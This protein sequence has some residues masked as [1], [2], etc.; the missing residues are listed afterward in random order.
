MAAGVGTPSFRRAIT[1]IDGLG[2]REVRATT[3]IVR[4]L[5][6][7]SSLAVRRLVAD[8]SPL[9]RTIRSLRE[10][11][12]RL[13]DELVDRA[14]GTPDREVARDLSRAEDRI[15]AAIDIL[16]EGLQTLQQA[17]ATIGQQE[18][19]LWTELQALRKYALL[20]ARLDELLDDRIEELATTD[21]ERARVVR[22][23]ALFAVRRRRRDL[24]LQLAVVTQGYAALR[25]IEQDDLEVIWAI[26]TATTTTAT[27][28]RTALLAAQALGDRR[29]SVQVDLAGLGRAWDDVV[30]ALDAVDARKRRTR[31]DVG[32]STD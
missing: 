22:N 7:E 18:R 11:A 5:D 20:A 14:A 8:D 24:L 29:R 2:D 32:S 15:R 1:A 3:E 6:S 27:A 10:T 26:R 16:D 9:S 31:D 4:G 21:P 23:D 13:R 30:V 25:L 17:S 12:E 19:A 28:M